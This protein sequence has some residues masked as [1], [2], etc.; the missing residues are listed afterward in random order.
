MFTK[1]PTVYVLVFIAIVLI[2]YL[3]LI[4]NKTNSV[5][6]MQSISP[7]KKK[8]KDINSEQAIDIVKS[9]PEVQE[10]M[11]KGVI[12]TAYQES[13]PMTSI[14]SETIETYS[15]H[16]FSMEDYTDETAP[17]HTATFNWYT[18]DKCNGE[19]KC[20]FFI[21][22]EGKYERASEEDEYPCK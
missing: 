7:T 3:L 22:K 21:Y 4:K 11:N 6:E 12:T 5:S 18:V 10:F 20:S 16:V 8:C 19:I 1:K 14:D 9:R 2:S 15:I 13:I 17:S